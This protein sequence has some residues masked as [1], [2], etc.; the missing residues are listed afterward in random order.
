M[1]DRH[2]VETNLDSRHLVKN[3]ILLTDIWSKNH[4][5]DGDLSKKQ[6][7]KQI[8]NQEQIGQI[9][10]WQ[11]KTNFADRHLAQKQFGQQ[12]FNQKTFG[13]KTVWPTNI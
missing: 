5:V 1:T 8:F 3:L 9:D 12:R 6:F 13:L 11:K 7:G 10:I 4:F 2:L